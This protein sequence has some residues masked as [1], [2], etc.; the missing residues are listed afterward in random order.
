[1]HLF[2]GAPTISLNRWIALALLIFAILI[3]SSFIVAQTTPTEGLRQ[4]TPRVH[5]LLNARVI[6][7]PGQII[8]KGTIVLRNGVIEAVGARVTPPPDARLWDLKGLTVYP[9]LIETYS[10]YGLPKPEKKPSGQT[11]PTPEKTHSGPSHWNPRVHPE[12]NAAEMFTPAKEDAKKLRALGF[13]VALVTPTQGIFRGTSAVVSLGD[14]RP[15][16]GILKPRVAQHIAFEYGGDGYPTSLMGA[17]A[18]IRQT[19]LDA[20]WYQEAQAIYSQRPAGQTRPE[21]NE[22]LSALAPVLRGDW[23]VIIEADDELNFLRAGRVAR[24]FGLTLWVRGSGY[25][26]RRLEAIR[27]AGVPI[28][29]PVNFPE[30]PKVETPEEALDVSLEE[31]QHWELAPENPRR[32]QEAGVN[33]TLTSALLKN[34]SDFP[35]QVR[36]AIER[37]FAKDAALAALTTTPARLLGMENQIGTIA[38][39]KIANLVVTDGDLFAEKT[40]IL[41]TWIDGE[42]YE[43]QKRPE[44]EPRGSWTLRFESEPVKMD[45]ITLELKGEIDNLTGRVAKGAMKT[46]LTKVTLEN[47]RLA[48]VFTGDSL[49]YP[50]VIRM[51]GFLSAEAITGTGNLGDGRLF[52]W[53]ATRKAPFTPEKPKEKAKPDTLRAL[54]ILTYPLGA[55]GRTGPPPQPKHLV[56][57]GATIW[58]CGPQGRLENADLLVTS[59]KIAKVGQGL[60]APPE[61]VIIDARGKHVTP[62]LIDAH[63]H[64]AIDGGV[65]EVGN[66]VTAEVR[67]ED[68]LDSDDIA[69]Y[70]ELA[71]GLTCSN[72]LHGSA[73]PIGGQNA[74]IKLRWGA[75]PEE[76]LFE[77]AP[78]GIKFALG[79]NVKQSNAPR[80]TDRYPQTRQGV[81]Q[82]IRDRFRAALDYEK[83]WQEYSSKKKGQAIPPRRDLQLEALLEV[84]KGKRLIHSHGYRQDEILML[85]RLAEQFGFHVATFQHV[86]EGYKVAEALARHRAG[87]SAFSDW[88][89]YKTEAYDAIPYNGALMHQAGI[90]VSY[91]SDSDELARRLNTEA[92]KAVKYGGLS[93]E[94]ALKFV[95]LNPAKQ[96][97]I[98]HRVGSLEPGKDADFVIW[99]GHPLS[100][101]SVC[102]QTWIDGRE[103]FDHEE[104]LRMREEVERER[105]RLIQKILTAK[106]PEK[107]RVGAEGRPSRE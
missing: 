49:G 69:L 26:Y 29:L 58:T 56:V 93:E 10:H 91:N 75:L 22:A 57:R 34:P 99:S 66:A 20:R 51:T 52:R 8:E 40:K 70:R 95:T 2:I 85:M 96:L 82:L 102:E 87:A 53:H 71:G 25:E 48:L 38:P 30:E 19:F 94:E 44:V 12:E 43:V 9:G 13:T 41:E 35:A 36:R 15:N 3:F 45:T 79:E 11:G 16:K 62:G 32:L 73:N 33:F 89:A 100:T 47:K 90:V 76:M 21:L 55:F 37:G 17:I 4:N 103:Y 24:E 81:E 101:Y 74:V 68:V 83:A 77:G 65:N 80:P 60:S 50:G 63:S 72:E 67:I 18:L 61:A 46:A 39:G 5:A 98:D 64:T 54:T 7:S 27:R 92:A 84:L 1:M 31:L 105:E 23:P 78:S 28:I 88:W 59:G 97:G 6:P 107:E 104:D 106:R 42:R 14:D 86:L